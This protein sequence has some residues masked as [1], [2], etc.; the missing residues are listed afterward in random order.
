MISLALSNTIHGINGGYWRRLGLGASF[1]RLAIVYCVIFIL[2][3]CFKIPAA[4]NA[5]AGCPWWEQIAT[6]KLVAQGF[7][8]AFMRGDDLGV[9]RHARGLAFDHGFVFQ[10]RELAIRRGGAVGPLRAGATGGEV[11]IPTPLEIWT[12]W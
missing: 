2:V 9:R 7:D 1:N 11:I 12:I 3:V 5:M 4:I 10:A 8:R 6:F